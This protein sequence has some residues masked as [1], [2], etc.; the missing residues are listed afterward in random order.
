MSDGGMLVGA[1]VLGGT[2]LAGTGVAGGWPVG[3]A[4]AIVC[5]YESTPTTLGR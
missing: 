3:C 2:S 5:P 4:G 1:V